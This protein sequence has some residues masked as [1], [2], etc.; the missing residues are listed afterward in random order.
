MKKKILVGILLAATVLTTTPVATATAY[1][2]SV[3]V[4]TQT[5][6][7]KHKKKAKTIGTLQGG[8]DFESGK[9]TKM[10]FYYHPNNIDPDTKKG[11]ALKFKL[12][13]VGVNNKTYKKPKKVA[14]LKYS[15]EIRVKGAGHYEATVKIK[16]NWKYAENGICYRYAVIDKKGR[17]SD[18]VKLFVLKSL[19]KDKENDATEDSE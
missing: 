14:T 17:R 12:Y 9:K 5:N 19:E 6:A 11:S 16:K 4:S 13:E 2:G 3:A 7:S 10:T 18:E 8:K 1:A 15:N